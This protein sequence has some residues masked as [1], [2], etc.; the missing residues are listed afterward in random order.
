[1]SEKTYYLSSTKSALKPFARKYLE[2]NS[3]EIAYISNFDYELEV[4]CPK[5]K[6]IIRRDPSDA[7]LPSSPRLLQCITM[8]EQMGFISLRRAR[9]LEESIKSS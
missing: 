6:G 2:L 3:G 4:E 9:E 8:L 7:P 1:M 5:C